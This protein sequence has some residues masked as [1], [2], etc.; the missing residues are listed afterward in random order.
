[1]FTMFLQ[2][3]YTLIPTV[4]TKGGCCLDSISDKIFNNNLRINF[5]VEMC[6][7]RQWL[8]SEIYLYGS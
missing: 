8:V 5:L 6:L 4:Q 1:M 2:H 7:N 3:I